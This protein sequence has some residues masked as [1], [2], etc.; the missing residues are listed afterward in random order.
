MSERAYIVA[1]QKILDTSVSVIATSEDDAMHKAEILLEN[2]EID[3][4][5][6]YATVERNAIAVLN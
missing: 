5:S 4:E 2:E 3:W 1:V 6:Q